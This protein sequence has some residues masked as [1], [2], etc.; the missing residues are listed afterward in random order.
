MT[1]LLS[2]AVLIAQVPGFLDRITDPIVGGNF[3]I[4]ALV[5][6]ALY[7]LLAMGFVIIFKATQVLNFAHGTIA[8]A[9]AYLT[10]AVSVKFDIPGRFFADDA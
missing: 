10:F 9:G 1:S 8:A 3:I 5:L 6:G 4:R 2:G 7:A